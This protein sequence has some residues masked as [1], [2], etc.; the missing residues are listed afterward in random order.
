MCSCLCQHAPRLPYIGQSIVYYIISADVGAG[1]GER[2]VPGC[3]APRRRR[4]QSTPTSGGGIFALGA[5]PFRRL[6]VCIRAVSTLKL[7]QSAYTRK[8]TFPITNLEHHCREHGGNC[9]KYCHTALHLAFLRNDVPQNPQQ[10]A[11]E[12]LGIQEIPQFDCTLLSH[13]AG[14]VGNSHGVLELKDEELR[15]M[16]RACDYAVHTMVTHTSE[17]LNSVEA[18][19]E[20]SPI[21]R[22][23]SEI[24]TDIFHFARQCRGLDSSDGL[25][26]SAPINVSLVSIGGEISL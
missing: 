13:M 24:I 11:E 3:R 6:T 7:H 9:N 2:S 21:Y 26:R 19:N 20:R 1:W 5:V 12:D 25:L 10:N 4:S 15:V 17:M 23:P 18:C 14:S 16:T 8:G 22:L